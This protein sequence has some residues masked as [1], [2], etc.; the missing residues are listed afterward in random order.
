MI[1][2]L[3]FCNSVGE[4]DNSELCCTNPQSKMLTKLTDIASKHHCMYLKMYNYVP[5][6]EADQAGHN[7]HH[8]TGE[9]GKM[10]HSEF[11]VVSEMVL[12]FFKD[13]E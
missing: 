13:K 11:T 3:C 10:G 9:R 7:G 6:L 2:S 5:V 1:L 8:R 12:H 4:K